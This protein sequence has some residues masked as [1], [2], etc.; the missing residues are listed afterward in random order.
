MNTAEA[1]LQ[2]VREYLEEFSTA[3]L[4]THSAIGGLHAR[5]MAIAGVEPPA[6]RG[7]SRIR[8]CAKVHE[9]EQDTDVHLIFQKEY[10]AYLAIAARATL[11]KD[12]ALVKKYW[13][14]S[15]RVWFPNGPDDPAI[16]LI[17]ADPERAEYWDNQGFNR[18]EYLLKAARAY[19]TGTTPKIDEGDEHGVVQM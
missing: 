8:D 9:I 1:Q 18:F 10:A 3:M 5:P 16:V 13:K 14:E 6:G 17:S 7:S 15:F 4:V 11:V 12:P 19:L 2:K